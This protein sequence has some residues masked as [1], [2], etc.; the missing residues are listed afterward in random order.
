MCRRISYLDCMSKDF[1]KE[2]HRPA[3]RYRRRRRRRLLTESPRDKRNHRSKTRGKHAVKKKRKV[4]AEKAK[5]IN[6]V[7]SRYL[8]AHTHSGSAKCVSHLVSRRISLATKDPRCSTTST[9]M[10]INHMPRPSSHPGLSREK[11]QKMGK[12]LKN[13]FA[14]ALTPFG[15][16]PARCSSWLG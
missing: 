13:P 12:I 6:N 15:I 14:R 7:I 3:T 16:E 4:G 5:S 1:P 8:Q 2:K 11:D 9:H 10:N